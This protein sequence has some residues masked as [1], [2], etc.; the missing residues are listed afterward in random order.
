MP[1][2][3][4]SREILDVIRRVVLEEAGRLEVE[5][6]RI[7]LFGSR[8]RGDAREDSDWDIMVVI[9]G[10]IHWRILLKLQ[11][12]VRV[13][14]YKALGREVDLLVVDRERFAERRDLWGS[15]EYEAARE[16]VL[17]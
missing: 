17:V 11:S 8:A 1:G 2:A 16:G 9:K 7:I 12:R 15:L 5:V 10:D 14:L 4:V 3:V 6:D 13:R